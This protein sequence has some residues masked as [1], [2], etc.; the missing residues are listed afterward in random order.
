MYFWNIDEL[1]N[2]MA[3]RPFSEREMLPYLIVFV[4]LSTASSYVTTAVS[5][6]WDGLGAMWSIAL[7]VVGTIYIYRQNGGA[8]G[9]HFLQRY[10]AVGWV[11]GLR[12]LVF[13]GGAAIIFFVTL[14]WMGGVSEN[15]SWPEFLFGVVAET[16]MYWRIGHHIRDV[17]L[18]TPMA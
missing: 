12:C 6:V 18:R 11:I 17:A 5:T 15:A 2:E 4:V 13:V 16:A 3:A 8:S 14:D 1:K 10:F 9:R 7:A